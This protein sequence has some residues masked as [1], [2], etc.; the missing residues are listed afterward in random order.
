MRPIFAL[1]FLFSFPLHAR[2]HNY[3]VGGQDV[4]AP[5]PIA[6]LTVGIFTPS[7]DGHNGSLCTGTLIRKDIAVTAA[8]CLATG[9]LKPVVI[10]GRDLHSPMAVQRQ[11]VAVAVNPKWRTNAGS[12]MDQGDIALVKFPGGLPP[13]YKKASLARGEVHN[14]DSITLAGY[15][16]NDARSKSGAGTLRQADV[17]VVDARVKKS[18]MILDQSHGRGACHG[19]SG[20]PA[21]L[22]R[23]RRVVLAGVTNRGYPNHA[24][25]DCG[26]Q[27]VY[28]KIPAYRSWIQRR[29]KSLGTQAG[30][31]LSMLKHKFKQ[32]P[33]TR[34][35]RRR[36][37]PEAK[38]RHRSHVRQKRRK[39]VPANNR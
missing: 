8:H 36:N 31:G 39:S 22:R 9:G 38:L 33:K 1:V 4:Q 23:G 30:R 34:F 10:F 17:R 3:I 19:D 29:E 12:G 24:P 18:E 37:R 11:S 16:I 6:A 26:H 20:G 5:D 7:P 21:F 35:T 15:G 2:P 32:P 27:V 25:D 14:G 13:G 28:S